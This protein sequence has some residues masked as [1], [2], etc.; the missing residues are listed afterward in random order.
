MSVQYT[1]TVNQKKKLE[2]VE[3]N[4]ENEI[5]IDSQLNSN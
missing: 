4:F 3:T 2:A 5:N 1:V